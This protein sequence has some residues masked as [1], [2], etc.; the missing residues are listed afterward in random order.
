MR[1]LIGRSLAVALVGAA[2]GCGPVTGPTAALHPLRRDSAAVVRLCAEPAPCIGEVSITSLGVSGFIIRAGGAALMTGPSFTHPGLGRVF[3][4][5]IA[6][7]HS[8]TAE[9]DRQLTRLLGP[10]HAE[11]VGLS[12]ILIGHAHYDH[13]MDT[14]YIARHY[15]PHAT[16]YGGLTTKRILMGDPWLRAHAGNVDSLFAGDSVGTPTR[17]GRWAYTPDS[18]MRFMAL[19]STHAHNFWFITIAPG[20][21]DRDADHLPSTGWGWKMG[22]PYSYVIDVLDR[23]RRPVFR[24][25]YEDAATDPTHVFLPPFTGVDR[26]NVD[27]AIVCAGNFGN[28]PDYPSFLIGTLHA[29]FVLVGHWE[30]FFR[31]MDETPTPIPLLNTALLA[32]R[33]DSIPGRLWITPEPG[34]RVRVEY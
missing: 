30:D 21:A 7:I 16:I 1:R 20:H 17:V 11:L 12:S 24:L 6:H 33:L 28:V 15:L 25:L 27:M 18:G 22:D 4:P 26:R 2:P 14:P 31:A 23:Q 5:V 19:A 34:A 3:T 8:D 10:Q 32:R 13:L 9:V 29:R